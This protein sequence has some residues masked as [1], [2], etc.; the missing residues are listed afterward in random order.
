MEKTK[1]LSRQI[2]AF[3]IPLILS[4]LLQ[5]MFNWADAFIVGNI[6]GEDALAAVGATLYITLLF[7]TAITGFTTG[8]SVL[9]AQMFGEGNLQDQKKVLFTFLV[10]VGAA[11]TVLGWIGIWTAKAALAAMGTPAD[12]IA[13]AEEYLRIVLL[14]M[15]FLAIY[16]VYAAVLR[17]I[18]DSR[19][20]F[21]AVMVSVIVNVVMD[22]LLVAVFHMG[23]AGA[24]LA[25]VASQAMMA[26]FMALYAGAAHPVLKMRGEKDL[27]D[28][29]ILR[30]GSRL[31][32]PITIQSVV[33]SL[34][35]L[36]LQRIMNSFG[37]ATVAAITTAYR[38]DSVIL[39]PVFNLGTGIS[40]LAAQNTGAGE[41]RRA[42]ECLYVGC[43]LMAVV[44]VALA[45]VVLVFGGP[46][47][48]MFG[49]TAQATAI[50]VEFF[51]CIVWFY[52]I[53][54]W[55]M[56]FRGYL[57]GTGDVGFSGFT[58]I[59]SL[60]VRIV[61]SYALMDVFGNMV[62]AYAEA[63]AWCF[64]LALFVLRFVWKNRRIT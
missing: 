15:P 30:R 44:S 46:L 12:I 43:G 63:F 14:G 36:V 47:I 13:L 8:V 56:A 22:L 29:E 42:R 10:V 23:V 2:I 31:A 64:M 41:H 20:P 58:G 27:F 3:S 38:V 7:V 33:N 35:G 45:V 24:A 11:F 52:I 39:L 17:G 61:L 59:V 62:I 28:R 9:S 57:E 1:S 6:V 40:T 34:G 18:G 16:N 53:N 21:W 26:L 54:G 48:A 4:G 55:A 37:T 25:T 60:V 19:T 5:Q 49:V 51:H 50:G 32:A